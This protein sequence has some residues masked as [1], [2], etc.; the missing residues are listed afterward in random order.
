MTNS[1]TVWVGLIVV[2]LIAIGAY[3]FPKIQA[4][5][6]GVSNLDTLEVTGLA[7]GSGCGNEFTTCTGTTATKHLFGTCTLT[8]TAGRLPLATSSL[9][10]DCS[11]TSVTSGDNVRVTLPSDGGSL[12]GTPGIILSY[13]K[14][15]T[16][17]DSIQV[18]LAI[19]FGAHSSVAT[20]SFPLATTSVLWEAWDN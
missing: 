17:A 7:V 6:G 3:F 10:F 19:P 9:P 13:A 2:A 15:S 14:A 4:S 5:F 18:W 20:S 8:T 11:A 16:T 12:G 1:K